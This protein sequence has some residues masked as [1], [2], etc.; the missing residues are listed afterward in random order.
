MFLLKLNNNNGF[1]EP[2]VPD[3]NK[4]MLNKQPDMLLFGLAFEF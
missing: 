2:G 3:K 1:R 4:N